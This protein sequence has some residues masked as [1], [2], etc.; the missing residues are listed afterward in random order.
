VKPG[1]FEQL[2]SDLRPES[3]LGAMLTLGTLV[4]LAG[5]LYLLGPSLAKFRELESKGPQTTL[6]N[7]SKAQADGQLAVA[8][9]EEELEQLRK[10]LYGGPADLPIEKTE[11][12]IID[13]LDRISGRHAIELVSVKP[14]EA[15]EVLM[16]DEFLYEVEIEGDFFALVAWLREVERDLRP[17]VVNQ[18]DLKPAAGDE[19][20][21]MKLRL[22][23]YRPR[24]EGA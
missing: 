7:F 3:A 21:A 6:A 2:L 24:A 9:L 10:R 13:R 19:V 22:A 16:F 8:A 11:S 18:F 5:Y 14:G 23:S 15:K 12:Y 4:L 1:G 20:V 17:M